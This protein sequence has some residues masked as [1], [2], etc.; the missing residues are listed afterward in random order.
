M[1][2]GLRNRP[3]IFETEIRRVVL[4]KIKLVHLEEEILNRYPTEISYGMQ[5]RVSIARTLAP[6]P[7]YLLFDEPTTG[8]DPVTT[9]AINRLIFELSRALKVTSVVV[10]HDMGCALGIADRILVLDQARVLA[11]GTVEEIK[12]SKEPLI[13]D[14]LSEA[15]SSSRHERLHFVS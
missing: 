3:G 7:S 11:L 1:A 4:E 9:N 14:F 13:V 5:K 6:A 8:L 10:S 12:N 15:W 2:F